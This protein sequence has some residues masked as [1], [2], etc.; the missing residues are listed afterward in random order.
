M[1]ARMVLIVGAS[2]AGLVVARNVLA[3][4]GYQVLTSGT[5]G[6]GLK[7]ARQIVPEIVL[8][9]DAITQ[10]S[11]IR[12][13]LELVPA[14]SRVVLTVPRGR[15]AEFI[16]A[17][18][19][20]QAWPLSRGVSV[21]EKPYD[22]EALL[23]AVRGEVRRDPA[24]S[25][26]I[27]DDDDTQVVE[28]VVLRGRIGPVSVEQVLQLAENTDGS[29]CC[30]FED[31]RSWIEVYLRSR[32]VVFAAREGAPELGTEAVIYE[33]L[34]WKNASFRVLTHAA[35]PPGIASANLALAP[36]LL[37]GMFQLD[38]CARTDSLPS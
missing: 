4:A 29:I 31:G 26:S 7:L 34:R 17:S 1:E 33:L 19:T 16:S 35:P 28:E 11:G 23:R 36:L 38:Q 30:R 13:L 2:P 9:D 24:P 10:A 6:D 25:D 15:G 14:E 37:E 21:I 3:R 18:L 8:L 22:G 27:D 32:R 5:L 12:R 20:A